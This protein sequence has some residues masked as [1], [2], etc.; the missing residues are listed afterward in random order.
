MQIVN[1]ITRYYKQCPKCEAKSPLIK[2]R[3]VEIAMEA[4]GKTLEEVPEIKG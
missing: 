4:Q 3:E 2:K 1:G